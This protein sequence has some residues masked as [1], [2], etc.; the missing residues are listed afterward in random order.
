MIPG[1][2]GIHP[3]IGATAAA[4]AGGSPPTYQ[5]NGGLVDNGTSSNPVNVPYPAGLQAND[6]AFLQILLFDAA[7][8]DSINTPSGWT[9]VSHQLLNGTA[10]TQGVYYK[11]LNGSESGTVNITSA[12]GHA[13]ND[14]FA[15]II[16]IFRGCVASGTPYESLANNAGQSVNM[17]G[18]AVTTAGANRTVLNFCA[19]DDDT[20][21]A[22]ASSWTEQYDLTSTSGVSDGGLKLYS[23][24]KASAGLL[25]GVTHTLAASERWQVAALALIPA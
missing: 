8:G 17:A 9:L 15:G 1:I 18:A 5:A 12:L 22:P 25:A 3:V 14:C 6:I 24:T 13:A 11:R 19:C 16:T 7:G 21:S 2:Q 10:G 23:I 20:L 4:M